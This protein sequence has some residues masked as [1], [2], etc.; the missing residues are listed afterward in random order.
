[1]TAKFFEDFAVGQRFRS[2]PRAVTEQDLKAFT[3]I[4][5]ERPGALTCSG[6]AGETGSRGPVLQDPFGIAV[7]YGLLHDLH[8]GESVVGLLDTNWRYLVPIQVGDVLRSE[9]TVT[10]CRR[11]AEGD[12]GVVN[13]HVILVNQR[14][15]RVQE[16]TAA[17]LVR[18]RNSDPDSDSVCRAFGT[19]GWAKAFAEL[20]EQDE[21]FTSAISSWDGT[22]GLRCGDDEVHLRLYRGRVI[23]VT[24]RAP[25]GATFTLDA[26]ELVWTELITGARNDFMQ[27]VMRGQFKV[28]GSGYEYLRLTKV[29]HVVVDNARKLAAEGPDR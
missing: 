7:F 17:V 24:R 13:R 22:I 28:T 10:R 8:S 26:D 3:G 20:L 27:R 23:E 11:T 5:G 12:R 14:D 2:S 1:M 29:L 4:S 25:H 21:R 18:A 15:E 19:T 6:G 9:M 16:G